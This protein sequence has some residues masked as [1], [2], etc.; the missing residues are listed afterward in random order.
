MT[1]YIPS[2]EVRLLQVKLL[3][4]AFFFAPFGIRKVL[5]KKKVM[6]NDFLMFG[7]NSTVENIKENQIYLKFFKTLYILNFFSSYT[8]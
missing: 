1:F 2:E 4:L 5:G 7:F 3:S 8:K 6:E